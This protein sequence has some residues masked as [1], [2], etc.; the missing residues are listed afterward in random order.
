MY[1]LFNENLSTISLNT[2][3]GTA[4]PIYYKGE[5]LPF[6]RSVIFSTAEDDQKQIEIHVVL[7]ENQ[8]AKDNTTIG[9]YIFDGI[10]PSKKGKPQIEV[11]FD[12]D[13]DLNLK[14]TI[15]EKSTNHAECIAV[16]NLTGFTPPPTTDPLPPKS[17][18]NSQH[19]YSKDFDDLF[20]QLFTQHGISYP[21]KPKTDPDIYL[22]LSLSIFEAIDGVIKDVEFNRVEICLDCGGL[23]SSPGT[24]VPTRCEKCNGQGEIR[25]VQQT[26]LGEMIQSITCSNCK[27]SGKL[28]SSPCKSC[29]GKGNL[30]I[31][32]FIQVAVPP[33][34]VAGTKIKF[35]RIGNIMEQSNEKGDVYV[36]IS[37]KISIN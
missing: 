6:N 11:Q 10:T 31:K 21:Q 5:S 8:L 33:N 7:G 20:S 22:N 30:I 2:V 15:N 26:F 23:G 29:K 37:T 9:K 13:K 14:I 17:D 18:T 1:S 24:T 12:I 28:I 36:G 4:V 16:L 27:G 34:T 3:D 32:D 35:A 25:K 19:D